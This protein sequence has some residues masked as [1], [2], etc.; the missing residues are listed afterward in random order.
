MTDV[1]KNQWQLINEAPPTILS[2]YADIEERFIKKY[3]AEWV[4]RN[5]ATIAKLAC[6]CVRDFETASICQC[7][8]SLRD[9][10]KD[11]L[12]SISSC[13]D[14]LS[15]CVESLANCDDYLTDTDTVTASQK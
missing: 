3:G 9:V 2:Y 4:K 12:D 5:T 6:A 10:F 11:R 7:I 14:S 15:Q 8:Q 13:I 1:T